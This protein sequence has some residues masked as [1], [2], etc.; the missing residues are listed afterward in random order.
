MGGGVLPHM[1]PLMS[2]S[3]LCIPPRP[4]PSN[5]G[6]MTRGSVFFTP[7]TTS[8]A[9]FLIPFTGQTI[10]GSILPHMPPHSFLHLLFFPPPLVPSSTSNSTSHAAPYAFIPWVL[11]TCHSLCLYPLN[12][13]HMPPTLE[14]WPK[15]KR[16]CSTSHA[17]SSSIPLFAISCLVVHHILFNSCYIAILLVDQQWNLILI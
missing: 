11:P 14:H 12:T 4:H 13:A 16:P 15:D 9:S 2:Y 1:L 3:D 10:R 8:C 7:H 6:Q 5:A 17:A